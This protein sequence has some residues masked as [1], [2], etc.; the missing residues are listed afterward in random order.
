MLSTE[1]QILNFYVKIFFGIV[2]V[3]HMFCFLVIKIL[4]VAFLE[5]SSYFILD[6]KEASQFIITQ[7]LY[8][9]LI[10]RVQDKFE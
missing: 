5:F 6:R 2:L 3:W 9:L 1:P 4:Y 8:Q 10:A 7:K